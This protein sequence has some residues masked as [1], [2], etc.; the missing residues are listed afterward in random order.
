M[1]RQ[2]IQSALLDHGV[3]RVVNVDGTAADFSIVATISGLNEVSQGSRSFFGAL[4]GQA[5]IGVC[6]AVANM[7]GRSITEFQAS[8]TSSGGTVLAGT[9][10]RAIY[11]A[12]E[13]IAAY[14]AGS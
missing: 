13:R 6:V 11:N 12:A 4:A 7:S 1:L 9:T 10:D 5:M 3:F 2:A 14:L 8:G